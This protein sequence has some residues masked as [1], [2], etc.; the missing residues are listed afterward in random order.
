MTILSF[1][2]PGGKVPRLPSAEEPSPWGCRHPWRGQKVQDAKP[3]RC[4]CPPLGSLGAPARLS[5]A[6]RLPR[7]GLRCHMK[8][9]YATSRFPSISAPSGAFHKWKWGLARA[10][11][12]CGA[13]GSPQA[14]E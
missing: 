14:H 13:P 1:S 7:P 10:K 11:G 8:R 12:G 4:P 2:H 3:A 5:F 6:W 9:A